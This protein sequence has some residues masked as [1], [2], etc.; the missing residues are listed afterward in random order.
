[1]F[2]KVS[3]AFSGMCLKAIEKI[4]FLMHDIGVMVLN[5]ENSTKKASDELAYAQVSL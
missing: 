1:V 2:L 3:F 4:V 5:N